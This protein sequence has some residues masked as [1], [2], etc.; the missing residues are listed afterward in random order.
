MKRVLYIGLVLSLLLSI[1][2]VNAQTKKEI[3]KAKKEKKEKAK[4]NQKETTIEISTPHKKP[5][6]TGGNTDISGQGANQNLPPKETSLEKPT[7]QK[8]PTQKPAFKEINMREIEPLTQPIV[9]QQDNGVLNWSE[10][11]IEAKGMS[12]IDNQ[13]FDNP[14]QARAMATRGAIVVA[15]RN[16]LEMINGV[17]VTSETTVK[18]MVTVGDYIYTRLDGVVKGAEMIGEPI[19]KDGMMLVTMRVPMYSTKGVAAAVYDKVAEN[20]RI[21]VSQETQAQLSKELQDQLLQGLAFNLNGKPFDPALF[22]VVVDEN[23]NILLDLS[24]L[25][26]P[27]TGKFPTL[28]NA[29]QD[30]FK[31]LGYNKGVEFIDVLRTEPG[32]IVLDDKNLKKINWGKIVNTAASIGKFLMLFI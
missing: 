32:K 11:F 7:S 27:N 24:K 17:Q 13:R 2:N 1:Q 5:Q 19:E 29:T 6:S 9:T 12:V 28:F 22:P 16:L 15:Q 8:T 26:D 18:D 25:Y 31:E 4:E 20:K 23:N 30:I 21:N 14:A 10:Q 3:K